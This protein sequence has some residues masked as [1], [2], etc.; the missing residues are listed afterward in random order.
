MMMRNDTMIVRAAV[1]PFRQRG[2]SLIEMMVGVAIGLLVTLAVISTVATM[3][4]QRRTTVSGSDAKESAQSALGMLE[5]VGR[6]AGT[7]LFYNG[8]LICTNLNAYYNGAVISDG[9]SLAPVKITDGGATGSDKITFTYAGATGGSS[10]SHLVDDMPVTSANY[11]VGNAGNL[12][13]I[14]RAS[15][16][17]RV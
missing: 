4:L 1:G 14:G 17:E 9:A 7:G 12:A 10:V 3:N 5:H 16:R 11:T 8:Q 15:C 2:F 6:I 13:K